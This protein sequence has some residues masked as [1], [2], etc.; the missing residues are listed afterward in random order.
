MADLIA[1]ATEIDAP[2]GQLELDQLDRLVQLELENTALRTR[3]QTLEER[4]QVVEGRNGFLEDQFVRATKLRDD[5]SLYLK[6]IAFS[7]SELTGKC[8]EMEG[9][10]RSVFNP[11]NL[12]HVDEHAP[13]TLI[14]IREQLEDLLNRGGE[15]LGS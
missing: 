15:K 9:L 7:T 8:L 3:V 4:N 2:N 1:S 5:A 13:A 14:K 12:V 10:L 6:I 11:D